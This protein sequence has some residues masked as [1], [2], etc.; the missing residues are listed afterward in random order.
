MSD[1]KQRMPA[2]PVWEK[3]KAEKNWLLYRLEQGNAPDKLAKKPTVDGTTVAD[4]DAAAT[5]TFDEAIAQ[6]ASRNLMSGA[7]EGSPG[8]VGI[9]YFPRVGA[10]MR[11]FD[12]DDC[13][14]PEGTISP[15]VT[16]ILA[17][18]ETFAELSISGRGVRLW[19]APAGDPRDDRGTEKAGFGMSGVGGKFFT[20]RGE[21][22]EDAPLE[23]CPA[24]QALARVF[25]RT[26]ADTT[27]TRRTGEWE[28]PLEDIDEA[29]TKARLRDALS[30]G[31]TLA[32][33]WEGDRSDLADTSRSSLDLAVISCLVR[34]GFS[35]SEIVHLMLHCYEE[36]SAAVDDWRK[37]N[38]RQM[39]RAYERARLPSTDEE[40]EPVDLPSVTGGTVASA[41]L[42][43]DDLI[44]PDLSDFWRVEDMMPLEGI[45][46]LYG[47]PGCGKTFLA[48]DVALSVAVGRSWMGREVEQCPAVYVASE[49]GRQA[50]RNRIVGWRQENHVQDI[51]GFECLI[52][53]FTLTSGASEFL[54]TIEARG[55]QPGFV[56]ID[57]LNQNFGGGD[58]NSSQDMGRFVASI[59]QVQ[60]ALNCFVLVLH[61]SGKDSSRGARG[62][63]ALFAALDYEAKIEGEA[64]GPKVLSVSKNRDGPEGASLGFELKTITLGISTKGRRVTT[65]V[66][67]PADRALAD[68]ARV[69]AL[70]RRSPA[71][72]FA[73]DLLERH[74]GAVREFPEARRYRL[75]EWTAAVRRNGEAEGVKI[76]PSDKSL[77][78][79]LRKLLRDGLVLEH[80]D[81]TL[82]PSPISD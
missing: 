10:A 69:T 45:G 9:G 38:E 32:R 58:E 24:P 11:A 53:N 36:D 72:V 34:A 31:G 49:G 68:G 29:G 12:F 62:H 7:Q 66:A 44:E 76:P 63:S 19:A 30:A 33:R 65:C 4:R 48:L 21:A 14:S 67:V 79:S 80:D 39:R 26:S 43:P 75:S 1:K 28:G 27:E 35:F 46:V 16:E 6:A 54:S 13:V 17:A 77:H 70:K 18:R 23:V 61:H 5:L 2:G 51:S 57:T 56:V 82:S 71:Q 8:W 40:F 37:G 15:E 50:A 22:L 55:V 74:E 42:D 41:W 59:K 81:G 73:L 78:Q 64:G 47:A 20:F 60:R 3:A 52:A 25:E